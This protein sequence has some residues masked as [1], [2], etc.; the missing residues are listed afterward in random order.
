MLKEF[1][2]SISNTNWYENDLV[3]KV[4]IVNSYLAIHSTSRPSLMLNYEF[5]IWRLSYNYQNTGIFATII[6]KLDLIGYIEE[7]LL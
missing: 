5:T 4:Q 2:K 3:K 1:Q 6:S 7:H